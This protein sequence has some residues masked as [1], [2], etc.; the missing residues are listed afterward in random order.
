MLSK[1]TAISIYLNLVSVI[2]YNTPYFLNYYLLLAFKTLQSCITWHF[3]LSLLCQRLM[4]L[5]LTSKSSIN[6]SALSWSTVWQEMLP[7]TE[8]ILPFL[9][10]GL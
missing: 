5:N 2:K 6:S 7:P 3:L 9:A 4:F 8:L 1:L 10:R